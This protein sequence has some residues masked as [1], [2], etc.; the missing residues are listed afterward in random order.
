MTIKEPLKLYKKVDHYIHYLKTVKCLRTLLPHRSRVL[1]SN[2][3]LS[4]R[5]FAHYFLCSSLPVSGLN[6]TNCP[7]VW[8]CLH[9]LLTHWGVQSPIHSFSE[10]LNLFLGGRRLEAIP[11][12]WVRGRDHQPCADT[13]P[14]HVANLESPINQSALLAI[15]QLRVNT[16]RFVPGWSVFQI[17]K[18]L[19]DSHLICKNM[20]F[21]PW[22]TQSTRVEEW[23]KHLQ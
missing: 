13:K 7:L 20:Q 12:L 6:M 3:S 21:H 8:M 11:G 14:L 5:R 19:T 1:D 10:A 4:V 18:M 15:K 16:N 2:L 23:C 9:H 22:G 17:N